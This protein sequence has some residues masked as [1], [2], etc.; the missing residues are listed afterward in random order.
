MDSLNE[1]LKKILQEHTGNQAGQKPKEQKQYECQK[2]Q[3]TGFVEKVDEN[4]YP[5]SIRCDCYKIRLAKK[6]M[7]QSGISTEFRKKTFDNFQTLQDK[8][9]ANAKRKAMQY[10]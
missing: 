4:G 9:L 3:D 2:C 7:D 6:I 8:Q 5:I 10:V 1:V